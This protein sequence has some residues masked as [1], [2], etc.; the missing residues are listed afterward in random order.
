[1]KNPS[2]LVVA[3]ALLVGTATACSGDDGD[4]L[5]ADTE[6][7]DSSTPAGDSEAATGDGDDGE[8][9][10]NESDSTGDGDVMG[11]TRAQLPANAIDSRT[12]PI[13]IDVVRL[14]R[15]GDLV[16]LGAIL[17][18][19]IEAPDNDSDPQEY[20]ANDMFGDVIGNYDASGLGLVDGDAQKLYLP[21]LDSD[22]Q[23][24]CTDG[25]GAVAV[26][27]GGSLNIDATFG[28]VPDDVEVLDVRIPNFPT[29]T[30]V[31][32]R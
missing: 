26:P 15:N 23:C 11:T 13:R 5:R 24:L 3:A 28:G 6:S 4:G 12:T 1:M 32:I 22:G 14:E 31:P 16:E 25:L 2:L 7:I 30:G 19:E 8:G 17:T 27:P 10:G 20:Q 9:G 29:I 18:N 21:V